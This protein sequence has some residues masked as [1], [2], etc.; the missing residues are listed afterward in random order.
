MGWG[1][2]PSTQ[3]GHLKGTRQAVLTPLWSPCH[4][5]ER[6]GAPP[7]PAPPNQSKPKLLGKLELSAGPLHPTAEGMPSILRQPPLPHHSM[8][9]VGVT[10]Q[11]HPPA[12]GTV[13]S[14][15][16]G[17]S[18]GNPLFL[19]E[20]QWQRGSGAVPPAFALTHTEPRPTRHPAARSTLPSP[21]PTPAPEPTGGSYTTTPPPQ[22]STAPGTPLP[23]SCLWH[24]EPLL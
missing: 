22:S 12:A 3:H 14:Q 8:P 23:R 11:T 5:R 17:G 1:S 2:G 20:H 18:H 6:Q 4:P 21:L 9:R 7:D 15:T 24:M 13:L 10:M 16:Q 19:Q